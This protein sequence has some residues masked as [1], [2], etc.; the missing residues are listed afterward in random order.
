MSFNTIQDN[1]NEVF[2]KKV[3][4]EFCQKKIER[5]EKQMTIFKFLTT[6]FDN[7]SKRLN[8]GFQDMIP[9]SFPFK[10]QNLNTQSKEIFS[11]FKCLVQ[12]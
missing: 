12:F 11:N 4:N 9:V 7:I 6:I 8:W 10:L 3:M 1:G 2:T 5:Y